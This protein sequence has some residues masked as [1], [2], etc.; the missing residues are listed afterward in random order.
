MVFLDGSSR[1]DAWRVIAG[2]KRFGS[3]LIS[4]PDFHFCGV[5]F[6]SIDCQD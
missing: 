3:Y 6:V 4:M 1:V 2:W 5:H